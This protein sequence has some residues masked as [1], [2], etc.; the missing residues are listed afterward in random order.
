MRIVLDTNVLVSGLLKPYSDSGEIVRM[1]ASGSL[2]LCYD[3]RIMSEY[4]RVLHHE[5][6]FFD[7]SCVEILLSQIKHQGL[8]TATEPLR[9][10][11]PDRDDEMFLEAA[12]T[13]KTESLVTGNIKHYPIKSR[14]GFPV[15]SPS[16]FLDFYRK[17]Y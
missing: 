16:Q 5:K 1:V 12:I 17:R 11:L 8:V 14:M 6:F 2:V 10:K 3:A 15:L 4:H 7:H 9:Y 13:G